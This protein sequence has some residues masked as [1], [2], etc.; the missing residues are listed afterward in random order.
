M[1][2]R[3]QTL[4]WLAKL[5]TERRKLVV[6]V[7]IVVTAAFVTQIPKLTADPAPESLLSSFEGEEYALIQQRF[8]QWFGKR[9][10][11]V[12]ILVEADDVLTRDT[13]QQI[14]DISRYFA[15]KPW[16]EKVAGITT[17]NIP[18]RVKA[19]P[20]GPTGELEELDGLQEVGGPDDE[21]DLDDLDN[22]D[23]LDSLDEADDQADAQGNLEDATFNALLDIIESDPDRFPGGIAKVGPALAAELQTDPI[24]D[25]AEVTEEEASE[26]AGAISS[27]PLLVGRLIDEDHTV[28]GVALQLRELDPKEMRAAM[29]DLRDSLERPEFQGIKVHVG[30]LPYLR[31][32]IVSKMRADNLRLIPLT[33]LVCLILLTISFRWLPGVLLP[34]GAVAI[35]ALVT[36]GAMGLFGEPMNILNNVI[37][38]L[39]IIIG[40]SDATHLIQRY[41]DEV[42]ADDDP[43]RKAA[44]RRTVRAIAVACMLTSATT[45]AGLGSLVVSKTVMLRH[46]GVTSALGVMASYVVIITFVPAIL[47]WVTPP[48]RSDVRRERTSMFTNVTTGLVAKLL[49]W[50]WA[51]LGL[52]A[53]FTAG[54]AY[55][56]S[57]ITVDHALLDQFDETDPVY[58]TTLLIEE[59]LAGVRPLEV[60]LV[61]TEEDHFMDPK[62]IQKIQRI[63]N[64]AALRP[65]VIRSLSYGD[66]LRESYALLADDPTVR[67]EFF[68]SRKQVKGL[69]TM[70]SQRQPSPLSEWLTEDGKR[71]RIQFKLRDVGAQATM[72]FL[73]V[74]ENV[75]EGS[76]RGDDTVSVSYT[77]EAYTGSR[78]QAAVVS[79]LL[80]SLFVAVVIIFLL[81]SFFFRSIRLGLLSIPP[82]LIPLVATMAYMVWREIPLNVSTVI[83]FSISLGLA[84]NGTIH[85]LA[86]FREEMQHGIG[87]EAALVRAARGTGRAIVI[88]CVTLMAG[89]SVLLL[90]SF[91]PVRN[92][93]ELIAITI[94]GC[95]VATLL[96]LPPL[97]RVAGGQGGAR[98][99]DD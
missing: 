44:G 4:A 18:R 43:D 66:M 27:N 92:F 70:M 48:K 9:R 69:V 42:H 10:E 36:V 76:L 7:S 95:L 25:G 2:R 86:R 41:R 75:I 31:S 28:A 47:T 63:R 90:S 60:V 81:L 24:V 93:G 50:R 35:T 15:E 68:K 87:R 88:S 40:I 57:Q 71:A 26:L 12:L 17:L 59:K 82:N 80:G 96:V 55:V 51:V 3:K 46:F 22:L 56:A 23:D 33:V 21:G 14:H 65:E 54:A 34:L 8:E 91:V 5:V 85:V 99:L 38:P 49:R 53:L 1:S 94:G 97:L 16:V 52:T 39:L 73:D 74:L 32:V 72:R 6:W 45:A 84:V 89:F 58:T 13:L 61:S 64:W 98:D 19:A 78:G 67:S 11:A 37:V 77:G 79:D 30:G 29:D 83:I 20:D 62:L